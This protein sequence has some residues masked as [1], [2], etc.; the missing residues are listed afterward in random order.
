MS[1]STKKK[2]PPKPAPKPKTS[3]KSAFSPTYIDA[4]TRSVNKVSAAANKVII[5]SED[6]GKTQAEAKEIKKIPAYVDIVIDD[7]PPTSKIPVK[8][9]WIFEDGTEGLESPVYNLYTTED[10]PLKPNGFSVA[11]SLGGITV[12]WAGT[13]SD[14]NSFSEFKAI[15]LYA[16]TEPT[17][18]DPTKYTYVGQLSVDK[19]TNSLF[20]PVDKST[21]FEN[22]KFVRY[23]NAT[24]P[25]PIYIH[26]SS[27]NLGNVESDIVA[28][29]ANTLIGAGR[30][31]DSDISDGAII[32]GKVAANA[33]TVDLL[34][35][36]TISATTF[37]RAGTKNL[38]DGSGARIEIASNT[39]EDGTYDVLPG[40]TIYNTGGT[41]IFRADLNG[42]LT[43]G[44][45][46]PAG[47]YI[48]AGGAANDVNSNTTTISGNKI[49]TGLVQS[50]GYSGV[51]DGSNFSTTGTTINLTDGTITAQNFRINSSGSIF[52]KG[53]FTSGSS[54]QYI[55]LYPYGTGA[56]IDFASGAAYDVGYIASSEFGSTNLRIQAPKKTSISG[57]P[58]YLYL[59]GQDTS[60]D[61]QATI[62]A[63]SVKID[64]NN[65][66]SGVVYIDRSSGA[67][68]G[69]NTLAVRN[70]Y[71]SSTAGEPT[72]TGSDG[73]IK[74]EW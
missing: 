31:T 14:G 34:G 32:Y 56:R 28:N 1:S 44:G 45:Y 70:I 40:I 18:T 57:Q 39:V 29:V 54:T 23:G 9:Y 72:V 68:T 17:T 55:S 35:A 62:G 10:K 51:T 49:R 67:G 65:S 33:V 22:G 74:L 5:A 19:V 50:N 42:N 37:I 16:G 20:I 13:Y 6:L 66:N 60:Q 24:S 64:I 4:L 53:T 36:G 61:G 41:Q 15:K 58:G 11:R 52:I 21:G 3:V 27:I 59:Y 2:V 38:I 48:G 63:G 73:D 12:S 26:A 69:L 7:L 71:V 47:N 25:N 30:A 8:F 46:Q 43:I